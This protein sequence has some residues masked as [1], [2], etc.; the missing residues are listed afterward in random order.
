VKISILPDPTSTEHP[1]SL[2]LYPADTAFDGPLA[3]AGITAPEDDLPD[4][5]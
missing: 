5:D 1:F 3:A 2:R 4:L